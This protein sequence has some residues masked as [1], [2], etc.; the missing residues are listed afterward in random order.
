MVSFSSRRHMMTRSAL[1]TAALLLGCGRGTCHA[2]ARLDE[3]DRQRL[4]DQTRDFIVRCRRD[5]GS[6]APSPDPGYAGESDTKLSDLA[7][8]TYAA[9][10]ARTMGWDL[11]QKARSIDF[12]RRHQQHD[13]GF[14]NLAGKHNPAS[15]LGVL[16]N[17]TQGV[18]G[19]RALGEQ[20]K[21]DPTSVVERL[22][23]GD[24]YKKLPWYTTSFFP[25]LCAA[26]GKPFPVDWR[27]KLAAHMERNQAAD[28]YLGD[29]VAATFHMAHFFR[30]LGE[31]TPRA[32]CMV[33][34][35]LR[36]QLPD[37]GWNIKHPDWDVHACF[38][39]VF[40]LRQLGGE[41]PMVKQAIAR[42]ADWSLGCR[43]PDGGF[44]HFP[45]RPSDMDAV[46]FQFGTLF[47][48]GR[49]L[50]A[51]RDIPD[52]HTLGWG[53]AMQPGVRYRTGLSGGS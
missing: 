41:D 26:L 9:V 29:H 25:L 10:L 32:D 37:G 20:P 8:V 45:G 39:A 43:N 46:Y 48:A 24:A 17:T 40:I 52:A 28:G 33:A 34:R 12:I 1:G 19:L 13:G 14:V 4:A 30:L 36:D 44:A 23:A 51:Q 6:Y 22:L 2:S 15:D 35:V 21:V 42:G 27:R 38:D 11:P 7:A 3:R 16:Y 53:H 18:V 5:D 49:I 47:Q 31:P 50:G